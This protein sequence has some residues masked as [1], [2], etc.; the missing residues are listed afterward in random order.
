MGPRII[1]A[2]VLLV[3]FAYP[4]AG[5]TENPSP[6]KVENPDTIKVAYLQ[7]P[8]CP[9][10]EDSINEMIDGLLVRS[11]LKRSNVPFDM[12]MGNPISLVVLTECGRS[13]QGHY[14]YSASA[15][16]REAVM[17]ERSSGK[18]LAYVFHN[19]FSYGRI[20]MGSDDYKET[21]R[22]AVRSAVERALTDYLKANFDL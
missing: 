19:P 16:F 17:I 7:E 1:A 21:V 9:G 3:A 11:R 13:E 5:Q 12:W 2:A 14:I 15:G 10:T 22:T 8:D 18:V 20:G 4:A 6:L